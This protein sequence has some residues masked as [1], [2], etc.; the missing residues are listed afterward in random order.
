MFYY[1]LEKK[2]SKVKMIVIFCVKNIQKQSSG[3]V[4]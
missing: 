3:G 4:L 2:L 1:L